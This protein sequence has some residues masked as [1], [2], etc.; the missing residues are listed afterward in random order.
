M[1]IT[2]FVPVIVEATKFTFSEISKWLDHVRKRSGQPESSPDDETNTKNKNDK[3]TIMTRSD[4]ASIETDLSK[5]ISI[6]DSIKTEANVYAISGLVQQIKTHFKNLV[7][8]E[9]TE[10]EFGPL[11]PNHIKRGIERESLAI[12]EKSNSL[13]ELLEQVYGKKLD[14]SCTEL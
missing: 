3:D 7:D 2:P 1:D 6:I 12:V 8:L 4:F 9:T 11:T 14:L 5:F 10:A 13:K